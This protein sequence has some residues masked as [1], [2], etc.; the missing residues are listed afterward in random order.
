MKELSGTVKELQMMVKGLQ[1]TV[2][3][4]NQRIEELQ[5]AKK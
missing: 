2:E 4:Q 1:A 5:G 3:K